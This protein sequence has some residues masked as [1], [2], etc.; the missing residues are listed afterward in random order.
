MHPH[1]QH[2][3]QVEED[4][5][6]EE[7]GSHHRQLL[8]G[9]REGG[10]EENRLQVVA[11]RH[12]AA[13]GHPHILADELA[14]AGTEDG[15]GQTGDVLVGPE[16]DGEEGVD[17]GSDG[18]A[19][20]GEEQ[21]QDDGQHAAGAAG[22]LEVEG[23]AQAHGSAHEHHA[24]HAQVQVARLFRQD[25]TQGAVEQGHAV[26]NGGHDQEQDRVAVD[27]HYL[28]TSLWLPRKMRR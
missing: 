15:Q 17:E 12:I 13:G 8:Q 5:V 9:R 6:A 14:R 11:H 4:A 26:E 28:A 21:S 3:A 16:G 27:I 1:R 24:L 20:E 18:A 25:L 22:A 19:Q 7:Q 2:D 10:I 23:S